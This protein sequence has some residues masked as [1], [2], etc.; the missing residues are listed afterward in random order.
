VLPVERML[1]SP[2]PG[3]GVCV[4]CFNLTD[5]YPWCYACAHGRSVLDAAAPISYSVAHESLHRALFG[6]KRLPEP[7]ARGPRAELTTILSRYLE[8]HER[9]LARA[10]GTRGFDVVATVPSGQRHR[11]QE[12]PLRRIVTAAL[13]ATKARHSRLLCRSAFD[14]GVREYD[15]LKYLAVRPLDGEAV[16]L[17]D[18]TWTTG[19]NAQS[20]AAALKAA[21]AGRVAAVA[22]GR[23]VN[24]EWGD[25]ERRL[26]ELEGRF[27]W[28]RCALCAPAG[29]R[30]GAGLGDSRRD[31]VPPWLAVAGQQDGRFDRL[32]R[33]Q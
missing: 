32:D 16:L 13:G 26:L 4:V 3:P 25:N 18:D 8:R 2:R 33:L 5:G 17:V 12:H 19:A 24:R 10:A 22:I 7:L 27:D 20:A 21:G 9:C 31:A 23:H 29:L 11:D 15:F 6:Y 1:L 14:T 28:N 30:A